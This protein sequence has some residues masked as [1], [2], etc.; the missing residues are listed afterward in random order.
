MPNGK[1]PGV[2]QPGGPPLPPPSNAAEALSQAKGI[3]IALTK[4]P[5]AVPR[6]SPVSQL[7]LDANPVMTIVVTGPWVVTS[8]ST[9]VKIVRGD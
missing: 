5:N 9:N 7:N 4:T 3:A 1:P 2:G 8:Q 6:V